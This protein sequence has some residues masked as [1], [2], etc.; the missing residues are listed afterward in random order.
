[1]TFGSSAK[2]SDFL[3]DTLRAWWQGLSV[4]EQRTIARV[5]LKMANG[6]ESSGVRTQFLPRRVQLVDTIGKPLQLL[7]YPPSHSKDNP[8]ERWWGILALQWKG[9]QLRTVETMVEWAHSRT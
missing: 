4:K 5:P 7:S 2:T 9:M 8:L 1:M 6:P 3:V